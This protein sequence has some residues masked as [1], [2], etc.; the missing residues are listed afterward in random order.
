MSYLIRGVKGKK[1][2]VAMSGGVD[3]SVSAFLLKESGADVFGITMKTIPNSFDDVERAKIVADKLGILH[4][5]VDLKKLFEKNVIDY[6]VKE[7]LKGKN[8]N[9]CVRCNQKIKFGALLREA[10]KLGAELMATG[11]Y[12]RLSK[13]HGGI[14]LKRPVDVKKDQSYVMS[15]LPKE[16]FSK[17]IFPLGNLTKDE[18]KVIAKENGISGFGRKESNDLCFLD[19]EKGDFIEKHLGKKLKPGNIIDKEGNILGRHKG[20]VHYTIG[21]RKGIGLKSKKKYY[22]KE[23]H[24]CKNE[25]VV[26]EK[27]D[28]YL[29]HFYIENSNWVSIE[30]PKNPLKAE[31]IIR[32]K[33][34]PVKATISPQR[35]KIKVVPEK[36]VWAVSPGQIAV[37]I[38][39]DVVLGG[40]WIA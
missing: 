26:G 8:P 16:V 3:S 40:G 1:V 39:K 12:A 15:M 27:E 31:V 30:K 37:F 25:V 4:Y 18:V 2:A 11:H 6:F 13:A 34:K 7:S 21:Q 5:V 10:E 22:I 9:P 32:N 36:P 38:K 14:I 24:A 29:G 17:L 20:V 28:L 19:A 33:M 35:E 23:I